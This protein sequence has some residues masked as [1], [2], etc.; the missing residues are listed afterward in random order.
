MEVG[1]HRWQNYKPQNSQTDAKSLTAS[2]T[3]HSVIQHREGL[4]GFAG[5]VEGIGPGHKEKP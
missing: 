4:A 3:E 1:A 2:T 5:M